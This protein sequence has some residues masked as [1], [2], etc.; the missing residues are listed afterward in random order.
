VTVSDRAS[1]VVSSEAT[2]LESKV[3]FLLRRDAEAQQHM[4]KLVERV[5]D[6]EERV[7]RE[8]EALRQ[9]AEDRIESRIEETQWE[10]RVVRWW[11]VGAL[12]AG[13]GLSTAGNLVH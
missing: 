7:A 5:M 2:T 3:E 8:T 1:A 4:N 13:L 12:V 11:G 10:Y 6:L 9:H